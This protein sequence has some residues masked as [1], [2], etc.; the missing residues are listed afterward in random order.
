MEDRQELPMGT[1]DVVKILDIVF[2]PVIVAGAIS[3]DPERLTIAS[4]E[5]GKRAVVEWLFALLS[6]ADKRVIL[7]ARYE[8]ELDQIGDE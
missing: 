4:Y 5:A 1:V 3:T 7:D 8:R 6:P 2:K